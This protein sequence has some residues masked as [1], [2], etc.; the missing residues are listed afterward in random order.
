MAKRIVDEEMR[1]S[2]IINGDE[3]QK[4][5]HQL[6][7]NTRK[8]NASNKTLRAERDKLRAQGKQNTAEYKKLSASIKENNA[9]IQSNQA[10]MKELQ[11][12][13]GV[14]GLTMAQ[15]Q[16]RAS[17]LRLQLRNMVPGSAQYKKLQADLQATT[18]RITELRTQANVSRMSLGKL[19]DGF[20]RYA[21]LGASVIA[22]GTGMAL[23]FSKLIDFQGELSDVQADVMKTTG[24]TKTEV[25]ELTKSLGQLNTRTSTMELL[26]LGE[27][28]GRLGIEGV[29]NVRG[30]IETANLLKVALGNELTDEAI[31]EVGKMS[32]IFKVGEQTG[33]NFEESMESLGSAIN[34][35]AMSGA[36]TADFL[37]D[38]MK[39]TAGVAGVADIQAD[40]IIGIAAAFDELGQSREVSAT[41]INKTL[42]A[43]GKDV[44]KFANVAGVSVGEFSKLLEEDANEALVKFLEGLQK[45]NP[46]MEEMAKRLDGIDVG[47][48]RG[49]QAIAALAGN[50][51]LLR[52]RQLQANQA[53]MENTSLQDEYNIKNENTAALLAKIRRRFIAFFMSEEI[54]NGIGNAVNWIA[55]FVGAAED[56]DGSVARF[57]NGL[58][59]LIKILTILT[60]AV[61]SYNAAIAISAV[62]TGKAMQ[63]SILYNVALKAKNATLYITTALSRAYAIAVSLLT[64]KIKLAT[65]AQRLFNL[66]VKANPI[67]LLVSLIAAAVTGYIAFSKSTS[68]AA[69]QQRMINNL[70]EEASKSIAKEKVELDNLLKVAKDETLSKEQREKA[71]KRLND[72]SP[73][74]LGNLNLENI[75]TAEGTKLVEGYVKALEK[76]ALAQAAENKQV[77]L[78]QKLLET[79]MK[80]TEEFQGSLSNFGDATIGKVF[81]KLFGETEKLNIKSREELE[82]YLKRFDH[83]KELQESIRKNYE[84][85]FAA[86]EKQIAEIE[87]DIERLAEFM[88]KSIRDGNIDIGLDNTDESDFTPI[89]KGSG[90]AKEKT[91]FQ[92]KNLESEYEALARLR[93]KNNDL[94]AKDIEDAFWREMALLENNHDE[95][96]RTLRNQLVSEKEFAETQ[97]LLDQAMLEGNKEAIENY[98]QVLEIWK[99]KNFEV[100]EQI[101]LEQVE[102]QK[103]VAKLLQDGI[104]MNVD[105]LKKQF[106]EESR[107]K[108]IERMKQLEEVA[109]SERRTRDLKDQFRKEDLERERQHLKEVQEELQRIL[110]ANQFEDFS[111]DLLSEEEKNAIRARLQELGMD[112]NEVNILLAQMQGKE[113][114]D[115]LDDLGLG[116]QADILGFTPGQW[117]A[118]FD[119]F[120][121][122][123]NVIEST[124][125]AFAA[126][127]EAYAIFAD[128]QNKK[129][130]ERLRRFEGKNRKE[131][132][133]LKAKLDQGYINERQYNEGLAEL[134]KELEQKKEE[135]AKK[136]A[137]REKIMALNSIA[138]NTAQAIMSIWAQVPKFDFGISAGVLTGIVSALGAAQAGMV[139]ST[140][141]YQDGL[142]PDKFPVQ[143]E[144]DGKLF[145]ASFGGESRS[146]LV[147]Q[148][149]VFLAGEQG[150]TAPEM[151]ISGGDWAQMNPE[152]KQ[153]ISREVGRVR[154]Y[155]NGMYQ[156]EKQSTESSEL[157]ALTISVLTQLNQTLQDGIL[158]NVIANESNAREINKAIERYK[159]RKESS[160]L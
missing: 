64:G 108:E 147:D 2:I 114:Q 38:F 105:L 32:Q 102:H 123:Q 154:G 18:A 60:V 155:Q 42:L 51:E 80:T 144:Q 19:A 40:K 25:D 63:Q 21:A 90:K 47:G 131:A 31:R 124:I 79:Q 127:S 103:E 107:L 39:R 50:T 22:A 113:K 1:F 156:E 12:Q 134:D 24:L 119:N 26:A 94:S 7:A 86:K 53:M 153:S 6:E 16:K 128:F 78:Q 29:D 5:L 62:I 34:H 126:M 149:T 100:N 37:V 48:T 159:K 61:F 77:E 43:M 152:I 76:K 148:P 4:E 56:A 57:R 109:N 110:N 118:M 91:K 65:A 10:R 150:K 140:K 87:S 44:E 20:N 30:F 136:Q 83:S 112:I 33:R 11:K 27:E 28:A 69:R 138:I 14:T 67:A 13:I 66:A 142:Y 54:T 98:S 82:E 71:I 139:L 121:N 120:D 15:L 92:L 143:R 117:D 8:L 129:D 52:K 55:K 85:L 17:Q 89:S 104:Q 41:A 137:R 125:M 23:T 35:I 74:Y 81:D 73:E 130:Q 3:A 75:K 84:P 111:L 157:S 93:K 59:N 141:G 95:K 97:T 101:R 116:G 122:L 58:V 146:G 115:A 9:T 133:Q 145:N 132:E 158:A 46:T 45:G 99:H 135:I 88:N 68:R 160:K 106:E 36:N 151:I 49:V 72:I 70:H 96:M